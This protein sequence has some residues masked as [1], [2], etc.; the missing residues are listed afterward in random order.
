MA[1][2]QPE[3]P[4]HLQALQRVEQ[5]D[6]QL[7]GVNVVINELRERKKTLGSGVGLLTSTNAQTPQMWSYPVNEI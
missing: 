3:L 2:E 5:V 1:T 6:A 4:L 7:D